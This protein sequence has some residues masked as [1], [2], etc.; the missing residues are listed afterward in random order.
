MWWS[1]QRSCL[2]LTARSN[3]SRDQSTS[4]ST[5]SRLSWGIGL[6]I[7]SHYWSCNVYSI[8]TFS[9]T[10]WKQ[11]RAAVWLWSRLGTSRSVHAPASDTYWPGYTSL[12]SFST[13]YCKQRGEEL[14]FRVP[15]NHPGM[16]RVMLHNM[17]FHSRLIRLSKQ[18]LWDIEYQRSKPGNYIQE[19]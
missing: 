3:N 5:A 8:L 11:P 2:L 1:S 15:W 16:V 4:V 12:C 19:E 6:I 13:D 18:W 14:G 10:W 17:K 7:P 9:E